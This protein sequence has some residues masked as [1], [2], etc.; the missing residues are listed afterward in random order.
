MNDNTLQSDLDREIEKQL[1]GSQFD[2][3]TSEGKGAQSNDKIDK[4]SATKKK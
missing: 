3:T 4:N 1:A 2:Q